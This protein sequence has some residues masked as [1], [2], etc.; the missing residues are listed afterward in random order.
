MEINIGAPHD[1]LEALVKTLQDARWVVDEVFGDEEQNTMIS[2]E[3]KMVV[4]ITRLTM[5][6]MVFA[7][8]QEQERQSIGPL[9]LECARTAIC[10]RCGGHLLL[11]GDAAP[12]PIEAAGAGESLLGCLKCGNKAPINQWVTTACPNCG[13]R[14]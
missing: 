7:R 3:N 5:M 12:T 10:A 4:A 2:A 6:N 13:E 14:Q 1:R 11:P 9:C 8:L